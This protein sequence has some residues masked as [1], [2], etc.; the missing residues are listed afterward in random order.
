LSYAFP[1]SLVVS[2][3]G[4]LVAWVFNWQGKRN[5]WTAKAP[6][7]KARQLTAYSLDDGQELGGLAFD[8]EGKIIVY[9]R[10]GSANRA[11]EYPNPTSNPEGTEQAAWAIKIEGGEPWR[12]GKGSN[13][14]PSPVGSSVA[15]L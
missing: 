10:G 5:I 8:P 14:V 4:D 11:G 1:S 15:S 12:L 9:V 6:E 3:K 13:P 2:P 7:Y